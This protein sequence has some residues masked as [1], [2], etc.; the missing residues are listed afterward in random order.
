MLDLHKQYKKPLADE[1]K[2]A[3]TP[4]LFKIFNVELFGKKYFDRQLWSELEKCR[5][6]K[7]AYT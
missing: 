3:E 2:Y 7:L 6:C 4:F 5:H 1:Q